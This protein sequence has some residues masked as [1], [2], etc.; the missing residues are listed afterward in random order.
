VTD[1]PQDT[2]LCLKARIAELA[3]LVAAEREAMDRQRRLTQPVFQAI[4]QAGL[5]RLWA[6]RALGVSDGQEPRL[7]DGEVAVLVCGWFSRTAQAAQV[8]VG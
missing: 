3:P 6:P 1:N 8:C 5:L 2:V 4:A 7:F